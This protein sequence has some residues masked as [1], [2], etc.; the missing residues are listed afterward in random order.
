MNVMDV[1][2]MHHIHLSRHILIP[3]KQSHDEIAKMHFCT[4]YFFLKNEE[5][6]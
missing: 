4:F 2:H 1:A 6:G 5:S 3:I